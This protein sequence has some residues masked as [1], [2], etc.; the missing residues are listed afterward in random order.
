MTVIF[1]SEDQSIVHQVFSVSHSFLPDRRWRKPLF[2]PRQAAESTGVGR[3]AHTGSPQQFRQTETAAAPAQ[4]PHGEIDYRAAAAT[5]NV[6]LPGV[7][8]GVCATKFV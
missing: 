8:S 7:R 3:R 5:R 4:E 2:L 6:S 1:Y